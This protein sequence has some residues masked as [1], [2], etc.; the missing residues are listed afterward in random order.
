MSSSNIKPSPSPRENIKPKIQLLKAWNYAPKRQK[1]AE[2]QQKYNAEESLKLHLLHKPGKTKMQEHKVQE[3]LEVC[4]LQFG[5]KK[6]SN[7]ICPNGQNM[8]N[9]GKNLRNLQLQ[10]FQNY[11]SKV[12]EPRKKPEKLIVPEFLELIVHTGRIQKKLEKLIVPEFLEL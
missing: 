12:A 3:I 7:Y 10:N 2:T 11:K 4:H 8:Q 9:P 6:Q 1:S 5:N